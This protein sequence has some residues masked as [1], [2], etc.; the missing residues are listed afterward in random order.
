MDNL[1]IV[2]GASVTLLL[3]GATLIFYQWMASRR[4]SRIYRRLNGGTADTVGGL[5]ARGIVAWFD[6]LNSQ[7]PD[8]GMAH[9]LLDSEVPQLLSRAGWR[10]GKPRMVF[11]VV[12]LLLPLVGMLIAL[13][14]A[15]SKW[16]NPIGSPLVTTLLIVAIVG[17]LMPKMALRHLAK[18]RA[19]QIT[20]EVPTLVH[21]LRTLFDTGL[22]VEQT[23]IEVCEQNQ[24]VLPTLSKELCA[25]LR[26][27]GAGA[28]QDEALLEMAEGLQVRDL[29]DLVKLLR[30]VNR[31]GGS[32]KQPL[33]DFAELL[34]DRRRTELQ[35]RVSKMSAKMTVVMVLCMFPALLIFIAGPG[36]YGLMSALSNH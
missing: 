5:P 20:T 6:S 36:F 12:Q 26:N 27:I 29:S 30:Q 10:G 33:T 19:D 18:K 7:P 3:L 11:L 14:L 8:S 21:L 24:R 28:D 17:Y 1:P 2:I 32:I 9:A 25:V 22:G 15:P 16:L 4:V 31:Y 34:H 35:E 23:L 13:L